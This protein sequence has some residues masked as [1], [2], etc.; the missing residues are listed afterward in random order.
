[1]IWVALIVILALVKRRYNWKP[2]FWL[3]IAFWIILITDDLLS[4]IV[5][6]KLDYLYLRLVIYVLVIA[7]II[8]DIKK[9]LTSHNVN[10]L[11]KPQSLGN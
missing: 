11:Q 4:M 8:Y 9:L 2:L 6:K 10:G 1:M 5:Y 7:Y 3:E